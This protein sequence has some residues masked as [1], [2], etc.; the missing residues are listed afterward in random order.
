[1]MK[2]TSV[3]FD[4]EVGDDGPYSIGFWFEGAGLP[5]YLSLAR[6]ELEDPE[7]AYVGGRPASRLPNGQSCLYGE[8]N[9]PRVVLR[10]E[11]PLLLSL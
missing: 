7:W 11:L 9:K 3:Q 4:T 6:D 5:S 2:P 10:C 1:M 8:R